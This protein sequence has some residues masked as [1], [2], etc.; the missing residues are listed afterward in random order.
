MTH[1][2]LYE[3]AFHPDK[4]FGSGGFWFEGDDRGFSFLDDKRAT[5]R[6]YS[7]TKI[8]VEERVVDG[9]EVK[10]HPSKAP[11]GTAEDYSD[12]N[13]QPKGELLT[14]S[15]SPL[16]PDGLQ[17]VN[18]KIHTWG[19]NHA[20]TSFKDFNK[21]VVPDLDVT[22]H[23]MMRIDRHR[24]EIGI[25]CNLTG[26]G[27]PNLEVFLRDSSNTP[28]MLCTHHR[29]GHAAGQL[30]GNHNHLLSSC[31]I[32]VATDGNMNF[33][34]PIHVT[35]AVD[36]MPFDYDLRKI[37]GRSEMSLPEWNNLHVARDPSVKGFLG[38]DTDDDLPIPGW[39]H[40]YPRDGWL[41]IDD[42]FSEPKVKDLPDWNH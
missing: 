16:I 10:S 3:R 12:P 13:T 15:V 19:K 4:K 38:L 27:F 1:F 11:W 32:T 26:D 42:I 17:T 31:E 34:G 30:I 28:L 36:F 37:A 23:L 25:T 6:V 35:R 29:I 39:D 20:F 24:Q 2:T 41:G 22:V 8:F 33:T 14:G 5:S 7:S 9:P 21:L 18:V 40:E